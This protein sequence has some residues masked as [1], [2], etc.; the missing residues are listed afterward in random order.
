MIQ[1]L[2]S[3]RKQN[4]VAKFEITTKTRK[5]QIDN[6]QFLYK[7]FQN[8]CDC[9]NLFA[10]TAEERLPPQQVDHG[11]MVILGNRMVLHVGTCQLGQV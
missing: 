8:L 6:L 3:P 4:S 11:M 2:T 5:L 7:Q 10:N 9:H 1:R